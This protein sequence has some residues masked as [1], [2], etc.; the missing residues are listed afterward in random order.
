[1]KS[2]QNPAFN[3]RVGG[4][5]RPDDPSYVVRQAD[6]DLYEGLKAGE[7]CYVLSSRQVGKSSLQFRTMRKLK[8][9]G[10][11]CVS[12][13]LTSLGKD[14][15]TLE[16][17]CRAIFYELVRS[18]KLSILSNRK[19]WWDQ[20][21]SQSSIQRL[22]E[23]VEDILLKEVLEPI[24][25]FI[26]EIDAVLSLNFSVDDFFAWIRA[27]YNQ[28]A[29]KPD[30]QRLSFCLLGVAS[31]Y[32]LIRDKS[33]TP[34]NIGQNISLSGF[35]FQEAK[36]LVKGLEGKVSNP[37]KV[38]QEI[39]DWTGG[40]PF[41]TQKLCQLVVSNAQS[42]G[43]SSEEEDERFWV[44]R[45]VREK[46]VNNWESQDN[47]Q[48]LRTIRD[49]LEANKSKERSLL[50]LYQQVLAKVEITA[51]TDN[52][53]DKI[54]LQL[55]GL[56][57]Q[58]NQILKVYNPIYERVFSRDWVQERLAT[59]NPYA[60]R[61]AAWV[62]S[63]KVQS[64]LLS[65]QELKDALQWGERKS[66]PEL[67]TQFLT[68]SKIE[69]DRITQER[70]NT[71]AARTAQQLLKPVF[72]E[73]STLI[74]DEVL[75]WTGNYSYLTQK[76]CELLIKFK[77]EIPQ[78]QDRQIAW[79]ESLF[80]QYFIENWKNGELSEHLNEI[81]NRLFY[82]NNKQIESRL[83]LYQQTL[84]GMLFTDDSQEQ[85]DLLETGLVFKKE[86]FLEVAN[87]FYRSVFDLKWVEKSLNDLIPNQNQ[88]SSFSR[89]LSLAAFISLLGL[90]IWYFSQQQPTPKPLNSNNRHDHIIRE[91]IE[92][93]KNDLV[94]PDGIDIICKIPRDSLSLKTAQKKVNE[95]LEN[96]YW[97]SRVKKYLNDKKRVDL[98]FSCP[99]AEN[100]GS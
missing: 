64:L 92:I 97:G 14:Y 11:R 57:V 90:G 34:F 4:S 46:V 89:I 26:D 42:S 21:S 39:L 56:V 53:T 81:E 88:P 99:A 52:N 71:K 32:E 93:G 22:T 33:R 13:D 16:G 12:I 83:K 15:P 75:S 91:A 45:L 59:L 30:Y 10:V 94:V 47:P 28:R 58:N 98:N 37:Y 86:E 85:L 70:E 1:M 84:R 55:S 20:R 2:P 24:V 77:S 100:L 48:H 69:E 17:W 96:P 80:R 49:R 44:S 78:A 19:T 60:E 66:L 95:W 67:E 27:C 8:S 9:E 74:I 62:E 54:Q 73:N 65:G 72:N 50:K 63:G 23:F 61:F 5:L 43:F 18:F 29:D 68:L 51:D 82:G 36:P 25:I 31:T 7:F 79:I 41:L 38:L 6:L 3:Y 35:Q 40:Q 76:A 87:R